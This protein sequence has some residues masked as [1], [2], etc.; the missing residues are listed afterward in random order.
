MSDS[1]KKL[2]R[3]AW[4][5][6]VKRALRESKQDDVPDLAAALTYRGLLA[7][8]P[9]ML[10]L[11]AILGFLGQSQIH[12][13][14][15]NIGQIAPGGVRSFLNG[16]VN[17]VQGRGGA[18]TVAAVVGILVAPWSASGYV[19]GFMHAANKT[20]DVDEGRPIWKT[21]P[22]RLLTTVALVV[23]L[24]IAAAIVL[25]TGPVASRVGGA[26][27]IGHAAVLTWDIAKWPVL[28][29]L[30]SLMVTLLYRATPNVKQPASRWISAGG[31]VAVAIWI[32]ASAAF[33]VY[34]SFSGS[35]N[36][37]YGS[38]ATAIVFLVWLWITNIAILLGAEFNAELDR[39][40]AIRSGL[41]KDIE[42]FVELRDTQ[43]LDEGQ[44]KRVQRAERLRSRLTR[45][46]G[47]RDSAPHGGR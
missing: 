40:H 39:E 11:V 17:Q 5:A 18:A 37:T 43:K 20:Y 21:V 19:A 42:P 47:R 2:P 27:G 41:P 13:L 30:V 25:L 46:A 24:V 45:P 35:Y 8:F 9:A 28:V 32:L 23:M 12:S 15:N 31:L 22:V 7:L 3:D 6:I 34:V 4:K 26:L 29:V 36:R 44:R 33:A 14:L 16:V 10:V 1:S 38:F